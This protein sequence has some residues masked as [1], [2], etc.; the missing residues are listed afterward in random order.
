MQTTII[1]PVYNGATTLPDCLNALRASVPVGDELIVVDDASTDGSAAVAEALGVRVLR[2]AENGGAATARNAGAR[3]AH[4]DVLLFVDADVVVAADAVARVRHTLATRPEIA[5]VFGSYD[6][7]PRAAGLVSQYRNLLHHFVHQRGAPEAFSFWAG[8]GAVRRAVFEHVGGFDP[9]P[10]RR[11]IED[12]ELGYRVH[13]AGYRIL[14]D[15][16]IQGT[17]L[18]RW[19]LRSM[20]WTD[21][22][23]RAVPWTRL[24]LASGAAPR[25]LNLGR[26][27]RWSVA[28]VGS[29]CAAF[30]L[31]PWRPALLG[32]TAVALTVVLVLNRELYAFLGRARG[33]RFAVAC[34]PLH[35]LYFV[36][37]GLGFLYVW[38]GVALA[39]D[40]HVT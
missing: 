39:R 32:L 16:E 9:R 17:H 30:L 28:L 14:L 18:K 2:L 12:I 27:Q 8:C 34:M 13:A 3:A 20:L 22:M 4:G 38:S 23:R 7:H 33:P 37:S 11:D 24:I 36:C 25:D 1:V 29:A 35:A 15:R 10:I 19:T 26:A 6:D 31:A 5:A 40:R 21:L